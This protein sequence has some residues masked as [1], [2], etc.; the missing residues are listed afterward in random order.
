[1]AATGG[2]HDRAPQGLAGRAAFLPLLQEIAAA[3][4]RATGIEDALQTCL[5]RVCTCLGWP[6]GHVYLLAGDGTGELVSAGLWHLED[7]E[8]CQDLRAVTEATRLAPGRGLPGRVLV[9]GRPE[10]F[11]NV[12]GEP[13]FLRARQVQDSAARAAFAFPVKVAAEVV[14]VLEFFAAEAQ[15]P[16]AAL[17]EALAFVGDQLGRLFERQRAQEALRASEQRARLIV[18]TAYDAFVAMDAAGHIIDWNRQAEVT[19]GWTRAEA[20]GR[21]LADTIIP[22]RYREQ[23]SRGLRHFLETGEGPLLN[24]RLEVTAL[25]R[26][27]HAFPVELTIAPLP[28][29]AGY[30]FNAFLQDITRRRQAEE[31]RDR[32]FTLSLDMLAIATSDGHF[33]R[34]NPAWERTLGYTCEELVGQPYLS[35]VHPDDRAATVAAAAQLQ[36]GADIISFENRYRCKDGSYRWLLWTSA[37]FPSTGLIYGAARDIT[38]RKRVEE[39]L[40]RAKAAAESAS[41]AKSEFLANMSHEIRTPM[42]GILGMTE[43]ALD[44]ELTAQQR[45]YLNMVKVSAESLLAVINDILD[46]SKIE[47]GKLHLDPQ[48]FALRDSLGD[49]MKALAVRAQQKGLELAYHVPPDVPD[50]L[51]GDAGRLRQVLVNL[52]GNAIKFTEQGEVVVRVEGDDGSHAKAQRRQEG[53]GDPERTEPEEVAGAQGMDAEGNDPGLP[54]SYSLSICAF[55]SVREIRLRFTVRDTGIGIPPEK[56]ARIFAAFEQ[57]DTSTSRQYGGT[58]LGL[59]I[60]A[61]LVD[62][63]GGRIWV[64]S[65]VGRGS[66]FHFTARLGVQKEPAAGPARAPADAL[67]GLP[68]LVVDDNATNRQILREML[69][70]WGM[71]PTAVD[72]GAAALA[73]LRQAAASG[74]PFR[75]V[76]LDAMMP[77]MDGLTLARHVRAEPALAE[78]A[79]MLLSSAGRPEDAARSRELGLGACL[80]KPVKPSELLDAILLALGRLAPDRERPRAALVPAGEPGPSLHVLLAEDNAVNQ[81]LAVTLLEKAG[82]RVVVAASGQEALQELERSAFDVVLMDVQMP[83]MDGFEA[84]ACLRQRERLTGRHVPVIAM[85]AHAMKGDRERCLEAGMDGYVAKPIQPRELFQA[86]AAVIPNAASAPEEPGQAGDGAFDR[87]ALLAR[88]G[89]REDRLRKLART[90]LDE[91]ARLL[92]E[93]DAAITSGDAGRLKRAAHSLKG[94]VGIFGAP[95][96]SA[97]SGR[98]EFLGKEQ[99]LAGAREVFAELEAALARLRPALEALTAAAE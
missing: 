21:V 50:A 91:S 63:M 24:R 15:E 74:A 10:W 18:E 59:S 60:S 39:A 76:L 33:K 56:Q 9:S 11:L 42:N 5:D 87:A 92:A 84:T 53:Q 62:M 86:L 32:F 90:F 94:S 44:T 68:V 75:L 61:R 83:E 37:P 41:R 6:I 77:Q 47:A 71:R 45:Q 35:F 23:H 25:H 22:H 79:L 26:D 81:M 70:I 48:P 97:A 64:E 99:D 2:Q 7:S 96:A 28:V 54:S 85:T 66:T 27:G 38:E 3:A 46:F 95:E 80:T 67:C 82:H 55:A 36:A 31:E 78:A 12:A 4:N 8:R 17:L 16:D 29:G 19:F 93:M 20:L 57:A 13:A 34:L 49:T 88:L 51:V 30:V 73:E 58:G 52:V 1:M 89:G 40:A 65:A 14:A 98:L 72:G 43:L 69:A